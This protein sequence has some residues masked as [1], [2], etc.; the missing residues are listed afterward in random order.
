MEW[1]RPQR[2]ACMFLC[3]LLCIISIQ[4]SFQVDHLNTF[5]I[6]EGNKIKIKDAHI[7]SRS[8]ERNTKDKI[9]KRKL[10]VRQTT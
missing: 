5:N 8:D 2:Q 7:L 10:G 1:L 9:T 3:E 6:I 4:N